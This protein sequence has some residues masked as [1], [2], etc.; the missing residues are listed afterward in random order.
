[1]TVMSVLTSSRGI[2]LVAVLLGALVLL[3]S[4]EARGQFC[5]R[6]SGAPYCN[7]QR[8][9]AQVGKTLIFPQ[10]PPARRIGNFVELRDKNG[11]TRLVGG[12]PPAAGL[13]PPVNARPTGQVIQ[14]ND[15]RGFG[16]YKFSTGVAGSLSGRR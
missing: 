14:L 5:T 1:M 8:A 2:G 15:G 13:G 6:L 10:G 4:G 11:R 16:T 12:L 7:G 9:H 3:L